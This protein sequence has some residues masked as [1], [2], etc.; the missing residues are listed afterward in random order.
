MFSIQ[1]W[2]GLVMDLVVGALAV[3]VLIIAVN[4]QHS[5]SGGQIGIALNV[6]MGFDST[7]MW[8]I[9]NWTMMET[10]LGAITRLKEFEE[11]TLPEQKPGEDKIPAEEWPG[12]GGIEFRNVAAGYGKSHV[13]I[14]SPDSTDD[15][16]GQT[17]VHSLF[18]TFQ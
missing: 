6:V 2:L 11:A 12:Y 14:N 7:L 16:L 13:A 17:G 9:R 18:D 3:L 15:S 4:L 1:S 10:S 5:T 8:T